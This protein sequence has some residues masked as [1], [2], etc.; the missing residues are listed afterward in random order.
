MIKRRSSSRSYQP[1]PYHGQFNF[2]STRL[3]TLLSPSS[4]PSSIDWNNYKIL[5]GL[6][7]PSD[8]Q[9]LIIEAACKKDC[10]IQ[11]NAVA[12]SGKTTTILHIAQA[13]QLI[14]D[15]SVLVLQYN[16]RLKTET[17]IKQKKFKLNNLDVHNFHAF[18]QNYY[19]E[20]GKDSKGMLKVIRTM[21]PPMKHFSY[22]LIIID[23]IQDM[24]PDFFKFLCKIIYDNSQ[25]E[26]RIIVLGMIW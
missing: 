20:S 8:E 1:R 12:G 16:E 6:S 23:E 2:T 4:S 26:C 9:K 11:V 13:Y 17:R 14:G 19:N 24:T 7:P 21:K 3:L 5:Q 15:S 25:K 10:N 22:E 18:V